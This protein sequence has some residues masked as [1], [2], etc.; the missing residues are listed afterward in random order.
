MKCDIRT[1]FLKSGQL[2]GK[3]EYMSN[4]V[5]NNTVNHTNVKILY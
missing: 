5:Q 2:Q 3:S 1:D 4:G